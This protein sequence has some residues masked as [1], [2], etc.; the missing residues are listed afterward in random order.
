M[1]VS[2]MT[3]PVRAFSLPDASDAVF[4]IVPP[5]YPDDSNLVG[6][7][8]RPQPGSSPA[9]LQAES[10]CLCPAPASSRRIRGGSFSGEPGNGERS[11]GG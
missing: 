10:R 6:M 3:K 5:R 4:A 1:L 11:L 9:P 2:P 8:I 7:L